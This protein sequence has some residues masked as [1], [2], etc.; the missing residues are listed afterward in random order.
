[1]K[2]LTQG[3]VKK[4]FFSY[5]APSILATLVTSIYTLADTIMIGQYEGDDGLLAL[6][7][8]LPVYSLY[9]AFGTLCGVGGGVRYSLSIGRGDAEKAKRVFTNSL[10][11]FF[12]VTAL[13]TVALNVWFKPVMRLLGAD[14]FSYPLVRNY[15]KYVAWCGF[16]VAG[17]IFLQAFI[18]ND[19]NP[20][21]AMAA[22]VAGGL[23]NIVLDYILIFSADMGMA[24][25]ALATVISYGVTTLV[26]CTHF[27]RKDNG[28]KLKKG[29]KFSEISE[30]SASGVSSFVIEIALGFMIMIFN[31]QLLKYVGNYGVVTYGVITNTLIVAISLFNGIGQACQPIAAVN[32]GARNFD[33]VKKLRY[34][35]YA[36]IGIL[37]VILSLPV[38]IAPNAFVKMF[39]SAP[40]AEVL[41]LAPK[42]VRIYFTAIPFMGF[43]IFFT[44]YYQSVSRSG[45]AFIL[46]LMRGIL[47]GGVLAYALPPLLGG[48][49]LWFVIP[50]AEII[51]CAAGFLR[52][53]KSFTEKKI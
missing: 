50:S 45:T 22:V 49:S 9:I 14:E 13:F 32:C 53:R 35:A 37:S 44:S 52:V 24:G 38:Q 11:L 27:F 26:C 12:V 34:L 4:H 20:K 30:V 6:N 47:I 21:L 10:V 8:F 29:I 36:A 51:T 28:L 41:A 2:D 40:S 46:S 48:F 19:K 1:M 31:N 15:G 3:S 42:A 16:F 17:A 7:I 5:L 25:G 23:L 39:T 43:N 33:N 18:R